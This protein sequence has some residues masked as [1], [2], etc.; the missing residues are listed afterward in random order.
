M[1]GQYDGEEIGVALPKL[2]AKLDARDARHLHVRDDDV[3]GGSTQVLECGLT[4]GNGIDIEPALA[5]GITQK[6]RGVFIVVDDQ[7][8]SVHWGLLP[9]CRRSKQV[10]RGMWNHTQ[11]GSG[12]QRC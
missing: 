10:S 9:F 5:Q 1:A 6:H 4:R 7:D 8:R 3:S 2:L 12:S 11:G